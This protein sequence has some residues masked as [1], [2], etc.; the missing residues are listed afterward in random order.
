M[1]Q[2]LPNYGEYR[3]H[4]A[5]IKL[6]SMIC[7]MHSFGWH[8]KCQRHWTQFE[9]FD[10]GFWKWIL[11][12]NVVKMNIQFEIRYSEFISTKSDQLERLKAEKFDLIFTEQVTHC[13][14]GLAPLLGIP[15]HILL[16]RHFPFL[17]SINFCKVIQFR[18]ILSQF[19]AFH[20]RQVGFRLSRIR[21]SLIKCQ[22][23]KDSKIF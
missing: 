9:H 5:A 16:S 15:I 13:G 12:V 2:I 14:T 11:P 8:S 19:W 1:P 23:S 10:P 20:I 21:N 4:L 3:V 22:F 6:T 17:F 18:N 7:M